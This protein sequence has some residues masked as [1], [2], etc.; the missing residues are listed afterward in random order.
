MSATDTIVALAT[1][2]GESALAL[3][4]LSGPDCGRI[5][6]G[7]FGRPPPSRIATVGTY[8]DA[9]GRRLDQAVYVYFEAGRSFT[10]DASLEISLH[11]N[12][13]IVQEVIED[14]QDRGCRL[15]EPGEFTRRAFLNQ[16]LDLSQAEA[17]IDVIRARSDRALR[18]AQLQLSGA[19]GNRIHRLVDEV[20]AIS[21]EIEAYIDFPE[22]DLPPEDVA[23]P[24]RRMARVHAGLQE[25]I[26]T[27][28]YRELLHEGIRTVILGLPNAGKSS[29]LNQLTGD[30]RA[31]V[32]ESPGTTR[33]FI[34]DRIRIGAH[35]V[36]IIDTA[37]LHDPASEIEAL[38]ISKTLQ[39]LRVA[40]C[41]LLVVD[42]TEP[43]PKLPE[44]VDAMLSPANTLV[45][46][47]K[48][49]RPEC[50]SLASLLPDC[51]HC[52]ISA[53]SGEGIDALRDSLDRFF[54]EELAPETADGIVVSARHATALEEARSCLQAGM[55]KARCGEPA[56]LLAADL[57]GVVEAL[58]AIV[59]KID[60]ERMLD[61]LFA[62]F[63][64]GK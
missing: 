57:R 39:Q 48:I 44:E 9:T 60:N 36:R 10:G 53:R 46:E 40:D 2:R 61:S 33:D 29:L 51:P 27:Q 23:G 12:P 35:T 42:S 5:A 24:V 4:R 8:R 63:C 38:G 25:L 3:V 55:E 32:S 11:G 49:D 54:D 50:R 16:R 56:E 13:F 58:G 47:N 34:E 37:G 31:I 19:L 45:V 21:A 64:I 14:I 6:E 62:S 41:V 26:A 43:L 59:G 20:I 30:D 7:C 17:V 15:A 52:R 1:P 28:H 22:E 18:A